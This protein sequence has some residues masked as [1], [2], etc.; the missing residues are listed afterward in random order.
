MPEIVCL[1]FVYQSADTVLEALKSIDDKVDRILCFDG[2]WEGY[3]GPD[4][5]TDETQKIILY[6]SKN[7]KS[8]VYYIALPVMH[9]YQ[10]RTTAFAYLKNGDWAI[11]L[12]ADEKIIEW[13]EDVR[14][15]LLNSKVDVQRPCCHLFGT[16]AGYTV[17]KC[18]RMTEGLHYSTDHRRV[19]NVK[20]EVDLVH[21][22]IIHIVVDHQDM[23]EK[24]KMRKQ[25][26]V[27]K[28]WLHKYETTHWNPFDGED[29]NQIEL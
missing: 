12:D 24:K 6:F 25:A 19:F 5:S 13:R 20:G 3:T 16:Y 23:S 8:Q 9:Q 17:P 28:D 1:M 11:I 18:I 4:Q 2:R 7:A 15:T 10:A 27:Y 21:G 22:P 26:D 29:P 14:E